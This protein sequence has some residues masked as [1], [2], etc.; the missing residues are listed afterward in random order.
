[1]VC[2]KRGSVL[3]PERFT[4]SEY[5][6]FLSSSVSNNVRKTMVAIMQPPVRERKIEILF[7]NKVMGFNGKIPYSQVIK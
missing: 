6:N 3:L 1:M 7:H 2:D 4:L 5:F